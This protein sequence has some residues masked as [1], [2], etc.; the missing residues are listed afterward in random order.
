MLLAG[1][2]VGSAQTA[3]ETLDWL[4][5][6]SADIHSCGS[7]TVGISFT[8]VKAL[9]GSLSLK[10]KFLQC[11]N[12][13]GSSMGMV[14]QEVTDVTMDPDTDGWSMRVLSSRTFEGRPY[15]ITIYFVADTN[16]QYKVK[17]ANYMKAVRHLAKL[18]GA[19]V[20]GDEVFD[21]R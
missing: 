20:T 7:K 1:A 9:K 14:W 6:R 15:V 21:L 3:A 18:N 5:G 17:L 10:P 8:A 19:K 4:N 11:E 2:S 16:Y 12:E 13:S